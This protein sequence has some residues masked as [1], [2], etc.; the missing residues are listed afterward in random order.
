M[1]M[2][3]EWHADAACKEPHPDANWFPARSTNPEGI[4]ARQICAECLVKTECHTYAMN[5]EHT[6]EGIW[7]GLDLEGRRRLRRGVTRD[8]ARRKRKTDWERKRRDRI[9][10][11]L[12]GMVNQEREKTQ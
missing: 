3:P 9:R 8:Q 6:L 12:V 11:Q 10:Q 4:R 1:L 5:Q 7:G 2:P